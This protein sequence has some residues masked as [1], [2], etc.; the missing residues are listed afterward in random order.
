MFMLIW[1][2]MEGP[3]EYPMVVKQEIDFFDTK[4]ELIEAYK[5]A[6][7]DHDYLIEN[8]ELFLSL[9]VLYSEEEI[10]KHF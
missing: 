2:W 8:G 4:E 6:N 7:K 9:G 3:E 1:E 10:Y 5:K